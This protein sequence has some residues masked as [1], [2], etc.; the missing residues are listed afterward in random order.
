MCLPCVNLR[1]RKTLPRSST[2]RE[3]KYVSRHH[4]SSSA[5]MKVT[6]PLIATLILAEN[7]TRCLEAF[8]IFYP[9]YLIMS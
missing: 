7:E 9:V 3:I 6:I 4:V 8:Y 1:H 5:N 2:F